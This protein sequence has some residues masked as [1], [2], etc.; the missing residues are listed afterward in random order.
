[1]S[2]RVSTMLQIRHLDFMLFL[3]RNLCCS[4][5]SC[6]VDNLLNVGRIIVFAGRCAAEEVLGG[7]HISVAPPIFQNSFVCLDNGRVVCLYERQTFFYVC[8]F[9]FSSSVG[10]ILLTLFHCF[11]ITLIWHALWSCS[12][13]NSLLCTM[14][15]VFLVHILLNLSN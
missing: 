15:S 2:S 1:M 7:R 10:G 5:D 9:S 6:P 4:G 12:M 8:C 3:T 13:V 11:M 14:K